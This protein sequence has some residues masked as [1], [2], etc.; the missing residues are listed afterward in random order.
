MKTFIVFALVAVCI[1]A[2][3]NEVSGFP[4]EDKTKD[5]KT[6]STTPKS[7]KDAQ[8]NLK[9][10]KR[11]KKECAKNCETTFDPVCAHDPANPNFKPR[12]FGNQCTMETV[13][14][15]MGLKLAVKNKGEC[16][17]SDGVRL[18]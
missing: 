1:V 4:N 10:V 7:V 17:G 12:T 9:D 6:G 2:L 3:C 5:M 11:S 14:C 8:K 13:A 18:S 16:P 15:E